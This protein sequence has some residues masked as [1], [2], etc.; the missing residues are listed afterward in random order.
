MIPRKHR[1]RRLVCELSLAG[2]GEA[3]VLQQRVGELCRTAIPAELDRMLSAFAGPER[4]V[5]IDRIEL[6]L[7]IV[8]PEL[9]EDLPGRIG[10]A[11]RD[12]LLKRSLRE[13]GLSD[14][15]GESEEEASEQLL[16]RQQG[17]VKSGE[18]RGERDGMVVLSDQ[19]ARREAFRHFLRTGLLPWWA[20]QPGL[21][22]EEMA[23][24][25]IV[26]NREEAEA[27]FR[28]EL[29]ERAVRS[30]LISQFSLTF[31]EEVADLLSPGRSGRITEIM[32][33]LRVDAER[34]GLPGR[35]FRE[36]SF[37]LWDAL[38]LALSVEGALMQER[39][40]L[41]TEKAAEAAGQDAG[42]LLRFLLKI[43]RGEDAQAPVSAKESQVSPVQDETLRQEPEDRA[44][45]GIPVSNAGLILLWPYLPA[46]FENCNLLKEGAFRDRDAQAQAVRLLHYLATGEETPPEYLL[47]LNKI[48]C[49]WDLFETLE[50]ETAITDHERTE[51]E[52]L[53]STVISHW[54]ALKETSAEGFREA[55]LRREGL[56]RKGEKG[57]ILQV[58]RRGY[59]MLLDKLP[60]GIA[61]IRLS[62]MKGALSTEW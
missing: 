11:L 27:M 25:L 23:M 5:Q 31:L 34:S 16:S 51:A 6:D 17:M 58:E 22:L 57:W 21:T 59:D 26:D 61:M 28:Q 46:F 30:R 8:H 38:F 7:G 19:G 41:I 44:I 20:E 47:P 54:Q 10:A 2:A 37:P 35:S 53:L 56:L 48:L 18:R 40:T 45:Y 50:R 14:L 52:N 4:L 62:W 24:D 15:S 12:D 42:L 29:R 49:G 60:W 3:L 1:I 39:I 33:R 36:T 13:D 43:L 32:T 9:I 55:F